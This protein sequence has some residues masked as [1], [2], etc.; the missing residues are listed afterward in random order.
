MR[1]LQLAGH[2]QKWNLDSHY[3]N[4]VADGFIFCAYSFPDGFFSSPKINGYKTEEILEK[5]FFDLQ[6]FAKK[7]A[8]NIDK[9][10]LATYDFH[11]A[12]NA[13]D[14]RQTNVWIEGLIKKGIKY[15][16]E[17]LGLKNIIIPNYYE[18]DN[19]DQFIGMVK[20]LNKWLAKNKTDGVEY[21]MTIPITNHTVIDEDKIDKLLYHLTDIDIVY[22]GYYIICEAKP[23]YRQKVST[24]YKYLNNLSTLLSILKK[25][26]FKT[27]YS[28][29]NWDAL[30]FL[31]LTDID[32]ITIGTYENLRNFNIKRFIANDD[33]GPSKGW[34]FSEKILNFIKAPLL[35]LVRAQRG[36][37]LIKN[38]KNIFSDAI[39]VEGY[40]WSNQKPEVHKNYLM[41]IERLLKE[42]DSEKDI[43]KRK[44]L[45]LTKIQKAIDSYES[46]ERNGIY[47]TDESKNYHLETWKSF[48]LS[49]K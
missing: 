37:E 46:L 20:Q 44:Q 16:I 34:Y 39:L 42:L 13:D 5:S 6:Y 3:Q 28:Y 40:P 8:G 23:D 35:D 2:I 14:D 36:I 41:A 7:E 43:K 47:L 18:N 33:G 29:A 32:Y 9:G 27:I 30:L 21:Y 19:L 1:V 49:K 24:D 12:A 4:S 26:K 10:K 38:E 25:Q 11:P 45:M 17:T 31:S 15:Q 22:D 48:L